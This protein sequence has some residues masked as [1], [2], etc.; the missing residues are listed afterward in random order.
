MT[1]MQQK[2]SLARYERPV[3]RSHPGLPQ[4]VTSGRVLERSGAYLPPV[5]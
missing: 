3:T 1:A 5:Q 2:A 4:A